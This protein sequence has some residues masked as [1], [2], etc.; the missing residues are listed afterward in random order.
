MTTAL[1]VASTAA[2]ARA[3]EAWQ[4]RRRWR[5]RVATLLLLAAAV[6]GVLVACAVGPLAMA[7]SQVAM[8]LLGGDVPPQVRAVVLSLR[9]PRALLAL[10]VGSG[11]ALSGAV[12]QGLLRNP[13]ADPFTLGISTGAAFGAALAMTLGA[14]GTAGASL[15]TLRFGV[16]PLAA[17][18]G[19]L[20]AL[21]A[22]LL[23][24]RSGGGLR[25]E[26]MVLAGIV[27]S[28]CLS[29]AIA[30]VKALDEERVT[31]IVFWIMGSLQGRGFGELALYLPQLL[32][33]AAMA[34]LQARELDLLS[35]GEAQARQLGVRVR[36]VRLRLLVA[37]SLLASGAVAVAGVIGFVGLVVPHLLRLL[38]GPGHRDLLPLTALAGG[39]GLLAA[40]TL[41]RCLL[42]GGAELPV[43]VITAMVGGPF[44]LLIMHRRQGAPS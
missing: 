12:F 20:G 14:A 25:R 6:A 39:L 31:A 4:H 29:A 34:L 22:V 13:L 40:D 16:L 30:L 26:T 2:T 18:A 1:S 10:A 43:G 19:G 36:A 41:S 44:F 42:S 5:L 9:L 23:L 7:P 28:T 27:I 33:G 3:L 17:L 8:A 24:G 21:A 35:L 15:L 11:L 37:A 38:V 32:A